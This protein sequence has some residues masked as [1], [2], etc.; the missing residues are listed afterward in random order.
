MIVTLDLPQLCDHIGR[1]VDHLLDLWK[2][3]VEWVSDTDV[4]LLILRTA[5]QS[6]KPRKTSKNMAPCCSRAEE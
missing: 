1:P 4:G 5:S 2:A 3:M 6:S